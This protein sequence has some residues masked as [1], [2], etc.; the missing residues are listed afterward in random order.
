MQGSRHAL[1]LLLDGIMMARARQV[2]DERG[3]MAISA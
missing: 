2:F 1:D 3:L